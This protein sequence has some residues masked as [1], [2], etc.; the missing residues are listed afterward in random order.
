MVEIK[1][2]LKTAQV[3]FN[4]MVWV[5]I[6]GSFIILAFLANFPP[7]EFSILGSKTT[8]YLI[9]LAIQLMLKFIMN[10]LIF[11]MLI[12]FI[13][14]FHIYIIKKILEIFKTSQHWID[15]AISWLDRI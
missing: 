4:V 10:V 9:P 5:V 2:G 7:L 15:S 8:V 3:P 12:S 6:G 11:F 1:P 13:I 14:V